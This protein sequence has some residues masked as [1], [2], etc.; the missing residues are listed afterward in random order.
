MFLTDKSKQKD[1]SYQICLHTF[2]VQLHWLSCRSLN[3]PIRLNSMQIFHVDTACSGSQMCKILGPDSTNCSPLCGSKN[4][5][6]LSH[7]FERTHWISNQSGQEEPCPNCGMQE[8]ALEGDEAPAAPPSISLCFFS[9]SILKQTE[10]R[11]SLPGQDINLHTLCESSQLSP[12]SGW[13]REESSLF[14]DM[15]NCRTGR[16]HLAKDVCCDWTS[17]RL[18]QVSVVSCRQLWLTQP[19]KP[20]PS[21]S[22]L[23]TFSATCSGLLCVTI[24][25]AHS[26]LE[27]QKN[28]IN[29]GG[30]D[31]EKC[32]GSFPNLPQV[33]IVPTLAG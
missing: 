25:E 17:P 13:G 11:Q 28:P 29:S 2:Q 20:P 32:W 12:W 15:Q 4:H 22:C 3:S 26:E 21:P 14:E 16:N 19:K 18:G 24:S 6:G 23:M 30:S 31:H 33:P 27:R 9:N 5:Q 10:A 8:R 1:H 7:L